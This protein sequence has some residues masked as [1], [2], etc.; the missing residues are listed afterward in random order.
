MGEKDQPKLEDAVLKLEDIRYCDCNGYP[1]VRD[2]F[3]ELK[4]K[5]SSWT[6]GKSILEDFENGRYNHFV[7]KYSKFLEWK[8][9]MENTIEKLEKKNK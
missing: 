7:I 8:K 4:N 3:D 2:L 9:S 6:G 1:T 5:E